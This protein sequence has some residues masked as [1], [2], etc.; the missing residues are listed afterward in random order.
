MVKQ[1]L[2]V[3]YCNYIVDIIHNLDR[4]KTVNYIYINILLYLDSFCM[5]TYDHDYLMILYLKRL[6]GAIFGAAASPT[7]VQSAALAA[8]QALEKANAHLKKEAV[9]KIPW[10]I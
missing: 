5:K 1:G 10:E 4:T 9:V 8:A 7:E 6:R 2:Y 3:I